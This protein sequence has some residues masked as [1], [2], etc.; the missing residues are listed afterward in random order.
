MPFTMSNKG[1]VVVAGYSN[2]IVRF[3]LLGQDNFTL[4]S[5]LKVH[6]NPIQK[7]IISSNTNY[8]AV[9][10]TKGEIFFLKYSDSNIQD[11]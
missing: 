1:R 6:P 4:L 3:L 8:V 2:G 7:I 10:S 5:A 11:I 9:L